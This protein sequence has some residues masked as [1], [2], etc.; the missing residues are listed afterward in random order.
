MNGSGEPFK[1]QT[2]DIQRFNLVRHSP[3]YCHEIKTSFLMEH[4]VIDY[5]TRNQ[6]EVI[7]EQGTT[8]KTE[9]SAW[10]LPLCV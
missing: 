2:R 7:P 9:S 4:S 5:V 8:N 6:G 10:L 1:K 3:H